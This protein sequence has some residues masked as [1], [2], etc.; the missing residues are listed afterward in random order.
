MFTSAAEGCKGCYLI[1][2]GVNIKKKYINSDI[3]RDKCEICKYMYC[4]VH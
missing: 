2:Q 4:C 1:Y 3:D